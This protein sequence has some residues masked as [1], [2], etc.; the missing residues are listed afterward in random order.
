MGP[1]FLKAARKPHIERLPPYKT[2]WNELDR[3][4]HRFFLSDGT[5]IPNSDECLVGVIRDQIEPVVTPAVS[6]VPRKRK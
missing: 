1:P 5:L 2:A 4:H 3:R 6:A